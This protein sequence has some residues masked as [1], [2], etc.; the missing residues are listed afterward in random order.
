VLYLTFGRGGFAGP[1][2]V[3]RRGER[4]RWRVTSVFRG[5]RAMAAG[6]RRGRGRGDGRGLPFALAGR[7]RV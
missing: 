2:G 1:V 3:C 7:G 6:H 5:W 4:R